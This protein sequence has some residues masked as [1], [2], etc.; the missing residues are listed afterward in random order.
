MINTPPPAPGAQGQ[1]RLSGDGNWTSSEV[2][3]KDGSFL[4]LQDEDE[5]GHSITLSGAR[6]V[7][8]GGRLPG[9]ISWIN[10]D[11]PA[12]NHAISTVSV[13]DL[14]H[15]LSSA[16]LTRSDC[17][18]KRSGHWV[19]DAT[20]LE[21]LSFLDLDEA[22]QVTWQGERYDVRTC[23]LDSGTGRVCDPDIYSEGLPERNLAVL[24]IH[25]DAD[26]DNG[27]HYSA[28]VVNVETREIHA[29]DTLGRWSGGRSP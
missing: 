19:V 13:S 2:Y 12:S 11:T 4:T 1:Q 27:M 22:C 14:L 29:F 18:G 8:T 16:G 9:S 25:I 7:V 28:I 20:L 6:A 15:R 21:V 23:H 3:L 17:F 5:G 24:V 26:E 10:P